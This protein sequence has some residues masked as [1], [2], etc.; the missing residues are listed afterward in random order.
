M[1]PLRGRGLE[2]TGG[3]GGRFAEG[4]GGGEGRPNP[5][6][7]KSWLRLPPAAVILKIA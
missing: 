4:E 5:P 1:G 3:N 7:A 2:D 6:K